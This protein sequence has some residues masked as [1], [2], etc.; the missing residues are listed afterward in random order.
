[1]PLDEE[2]SA[3]TLHDLAVA[4]EEDAAGTLHDVDVWEEDAA[5]ALHKVF[6]NVAPEELRP[7]GDVPSSGMTDNEGGDGDGALWDEID[8]ATSDGATTY[9]NSNSSVGTADNTREFE[10]SLTDPAESHDNDQTHVVRVWARFQTDGSGS[11][12][13]DVELKE[14]GSVEASSSKTS[15]TGTTFAMHAFSMTGINISAWSNLT[16]RVVITQRG[17]GSLDTVSV[18]V[19]KLELDIA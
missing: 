4:R 18:D 16:V 19:T 2:D 8:E 9:I 13:L 17:G 10:V 7:D 14:G 12:D 6:E 15:I 5:G 3:G 1:M 11:Y